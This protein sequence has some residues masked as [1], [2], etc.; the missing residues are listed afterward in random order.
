METPTTVNDPKPQLFSIQQVPDKGK[1][2]IAFR[3]IDTG[4][5]IISEKPLFKFLLNEPDGKCYVTEAESTIRGRSKTFSVSS[6]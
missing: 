6:Q 2:M 4:E 5:R 1:G 3:D